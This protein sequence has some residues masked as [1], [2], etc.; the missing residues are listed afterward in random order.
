M[1]PR[2]G[3]FKVTVHG[4]G[5]E[6][7]T[8]L[9]RGVKRG[10]LWSDG[11][12]R[13][14]PIC[15]SSLQFTASAALSKQLG[16]KTGCSAISSSPFRFFHRS[17]LLCSVGNVLERTYFLD[18]SGEMYNYSALPVVWM[19]ILQFFSRTSINGDGAGVFTGGHCRLY[20]HAGVK[21]AVMSRCLMDSCGFDNK[22]SLLS[23]CN[24]I[25]VNLFYDA[26]QRKESYQR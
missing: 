11:C 8:S 23:W 13:W 25:I 4:Y 1:W 19:P 20:K 18:F 9:E 16:S 10:N 21:N 24:T 3:P 5:N 14:C 15:F 7:C 6:L 12:R 17:F 26:C 2:R 22:N